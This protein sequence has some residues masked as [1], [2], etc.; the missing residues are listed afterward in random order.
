LPEVR[1]KMVEMW[2]RVEGEIG[3]R[4]KL[5]LEER[6]KDQQADHCTGA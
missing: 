4:L 3:E 5:A 2:R 1:E 6:Y